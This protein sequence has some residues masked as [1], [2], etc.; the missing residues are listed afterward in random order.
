MHRG[1]QAGETDLTALLRAMHPTLS[2]AEYGFGT[3]PSDR[4][5]PEG[6]RPF[7]TIAEDEGSTLVA[8]AADLASAGVPHSPGWARISLSVHSSLSAVGLTARIASALAEVGISA[9]VVAGYFHDHFFV[10]WPRRHDAMAVLAR[11]GA[12][13]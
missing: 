3:L 5:V 7:A 4:P 1:G 2:A 10:Q 11:L 8:P 13:R 6:L 12:G 9:N